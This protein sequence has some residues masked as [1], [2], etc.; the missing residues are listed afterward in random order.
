MPPFEQFGILLLVARIVHSTAKRIKNT[1]VY[2]C[3]AMF[4]KLIIHS[5]RILISKFRRIVEPDLPKMPSQIRPNPRYVLQWI[6]GIFLTRH[7]S[8][9]HSN[10]RAKCTWSSTATPLL[11]TSHPTSRLRLGSQST[12]KSLAPVA[13]WDLCAPAFSATW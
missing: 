10:A 6:L 1:P 12:T 11:C 8:P 9:S 5:F 7:F 4:A 13:V 2:A 3:S